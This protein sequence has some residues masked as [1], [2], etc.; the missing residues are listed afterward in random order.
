MIIYRVILG[1]F[2]HHH[3]YQSDSCLLDAFHSAVIKQ[4]FI[5]L[6]P[7]FVAVVDIKCR[8]DSL[9]VACRDS[10]FLLVRQPASNCS[11]NQSFIYIS[12]LIYHFHSGRKLPASNNELI[13]IAVF[14]DS[15]LLSFL[16]SATGNKL[17]FQKKSKFQVQLFCICAQSL[18]EQGFQA[19]LYDHGDLQKSGFSAKL[20]LKRCNFRAFQFQGN[21]H[22]LNSVP[23]PSKP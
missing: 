16:S 2:I 11:G 8:C 12:Y 17:L 7:G 14:R 21:R 19:L 4:L 23:K 20:A 15:F 22:I 5:H 3:D 18:M 1:S 9:R 6:L 10:L 13:I